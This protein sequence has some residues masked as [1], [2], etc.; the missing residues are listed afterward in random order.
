VKYKNKYVKVDDNANKDERGGSCE[1]GLI[2]SHKRNRIRNKNENNSQ[3]ANIAG[4]KLSIVEWSP[5]QKKNR[6]LTDL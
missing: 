5:K 4:T 3:D 1:R 6:V 2:A